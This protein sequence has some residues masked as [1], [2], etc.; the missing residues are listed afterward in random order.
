M[1]IGEGG[2]FGIVFKDETKRHQSELDRQRA[3]AYRRLAEQ[4][5]RASLRFQRALLPDAV[6]DVRHST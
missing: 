4:E 1:P 5:H 3:A 6:V 2:M